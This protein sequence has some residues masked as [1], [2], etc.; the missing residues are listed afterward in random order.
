MTDTQF[1]N[2]YDYKAELIRVVDGDTVVIRL[3]HGCSIQSVQ[4]VRL[5]GINAPEIRSGTAEEKEAGRAATVHL[6]ELLLRG[7]SPELYVRTQKDK[8]GKFGRYLA[9]L[10]IQTVDGFQ[11]INET[12]VRDGHA[13]FRRY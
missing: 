3:D 5:F 1:Q 12:M 7:I 4:M 2:L 6:R 11:N 9:T 13:E 8:T 10:F